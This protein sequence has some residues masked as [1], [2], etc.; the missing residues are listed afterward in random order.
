MANAE[1]F[2][3]DKLTYTIIDESQN[4]VSVAKKNNNINGSIEIPETI[5]NNGVT[6]T[7]TQIDLFESSLIT[8]VTIPASVTRVT[9]NAFYNCENLQ[10]VTFKNSNSFTTFGTGVFDYCRFLTQVILPYKLQSLPASTFQDCVS[11]QSITIPSTVT[12]VASSTFR[13]C[14]N[15][16]TIISLPENAPVLNSD[17]TG[18]TKSNIT[19]YV[20]S[21]TAEASYAAN[22]YWT[23]WKEVKIH[24]IDVSDQ[25]DN[26]D[27]LAEHD[28]EMIS[29]ALTRT[30]HTESYNS[31]CLPFA[32]NE[33]QTTALFGGGCDIEELT[34][35][36]ATDEALVLNFTRRYAIEAGKPYLI[37]P[38]IA[39]NNPFVVNA[40]IN[41]LAGN[42][43][44]GGVQ[45]IGIF[46]PVN[47]PQ[48]DDILFLKD[49]NTL[50]LSGG[51]KLDGL[52]AYFQL[53]TPNAKQAAARKII[54]QTTNSA[55]PIPT[56]INTPQ[57]TK[58]LE[59]GQLVIVRD[60]IRY[61]AQGQR[62]K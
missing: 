18:I 62:L 23:G 57:T 9:N 25:V 24:S 13:R 12:D 39:V 3:I 4:L 40:T 59:D 1:S 34:D 28:A 30:L 38:T 31:I 33:T 45:F 43:S 51:G 26:T 56:V 49:A 21:E 27:I 55:T 20:P 35:A 52:R 42:A 60:G 46:S 17:F 14:S 54:M 5:T 19:L 48:S 29:I 8:R 22:T 15:L 6:Y 50:Y 44:F 41:A 10:Y 58:Y 36:S 11:L 53:Q 7:V 37:Q 16:Q 47:L 61:S 32:L 2:T